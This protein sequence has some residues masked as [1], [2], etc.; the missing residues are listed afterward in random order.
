[1]VRRGSTVRVR[2]R[3]LQ[4]N[5]KLARSCYALFACAPDCLSMEQFLE[6]LTLGLAAETRKK[7]SL[8]EGREL[9]ID[10]A[11]DAAALVT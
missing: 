2:Q 6:H 8:A 7:G 11:A 3:A 1:M 5:C 4:K 10:E 9:S